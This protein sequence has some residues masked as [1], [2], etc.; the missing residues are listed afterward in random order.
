VRLQ[1]AGNS[2]AGQHE[3]SK[4]APGGFCCFLLMSR[5]SP[6]T[7]ASARPAA[8]RRLPPSSSSRPALPSPAHPPLLLA[9]LLLELR[10]VVPA[11]HQ[12]LFTV[13]G[14]A[15]VTGASYVEAAARGERGGR[16]FS[17]RGFCQ[18]GQ[19]GSGVQ[20]VLG[21][22]Q[23]RG[24]LLCTK[25]C[26]EQPANQAPCL[27]L[28]LATRQP[29]VAPRRPQCEHLTCRPRLM[30][31]S[32]QRSVPWSVSYTC[33]KQRQRRDAGI[34]CA[35]AAV[36]ET[37]GI[38]GTCCDTSGQRLHTPSSTSQCICHSPRGSTQR[39]SCAQ[40]DR[41]RWCSCCPEWGQAAGPS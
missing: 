32:T 5:T 25:Q 34:K 16:R 36:L 13:V 39:I 24:S 22:C 6:V 29:T 17:S 23:Y 41:L 27:Q 15:G 4:A 10:G 14:A 30:A 20:H 1:A 8:R 3:F 18:Q 12:E 38:W 40:T 21:R 2:G 11:G 37:A 33:G 19:L 31:A 26:T 35:L 9:G 7:T 28:Q